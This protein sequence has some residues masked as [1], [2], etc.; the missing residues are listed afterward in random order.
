[1]VI[2][3]LRS[4]YV[5]IT[6]NFRNT[7]GKNMDEHSVYKIICDIATSIDYNI[8]ITIIS[9][10]AQHYLL[11]KRQEIQEQVNLL[12]KRFQKP[13]DTSGGEEVVF[14]FS[15]PPPDDF[16]EENKETKQKSQKNKDFNNMKQ[17]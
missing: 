1:M 5:H 4:L 6:L 9:G 13:P 7:I 15:S 14:D 11:E 10:I 3:F 16:G 12:L 17:K 2:V 8:L